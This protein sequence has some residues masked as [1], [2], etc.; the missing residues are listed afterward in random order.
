MRFRRSTFLINR[1]FQLRFSLYVC[2]WIFGLSLVYPLLIHQLFEKFLRYAAQD[3]MGPP[4][5][6]LH[7]TREDIVWLL[8]ILQGLFL[9]IVFLMSI[10]MS[11]RIAGPLFKL[12]SFLESARQGEFSRALNFRKTDYFQE[13]A[14]GYNSMMD[15]FRYV[16]KRSAGSASIAE[17]HV[18]KALEHAPAN[19][20]LREEL[21]KA[22]NEL[23]GLTELS[24]QG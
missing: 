14:H 7:K 2:S 6:A 20:P 10:F 12:R 16:L 19:G 4:L 5:E 15:K 18:R 3:P 9:L 11:H 8:V 1:P 24:N 17:T 21:E 22:L 13:L 23:K